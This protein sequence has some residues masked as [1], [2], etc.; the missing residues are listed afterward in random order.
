M[1]VEI[2]EV[3]ECRN[4][5]FG[6]F[7]SRGHESVLLTISMKK[8]TTVA[9]YSATLFHELMHLWMTIFR[10]K[11]FR[12]TNIKEHEFIYAAEAH[13]WKMARKYL[14]PRRKPR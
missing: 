12:C 10:S 4:K 11:G 9:E 6:N 8:N 13:V 2:K 5:A 7:I 3:K 14:K 1:K